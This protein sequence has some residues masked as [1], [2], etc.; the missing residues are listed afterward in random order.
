MSPQEPKDSATP[1]RPSSRWA[2]SSRANRPPRSSGRGVTVERNSPPLPPTGDSRARGVGLDP[3]GAAS[4]PAAGQHCT[5]HTETD[6][7]PPYK[8][9]P[10]QREQRGGRRPQSLVTNQSSGEPQGWKAGLFPDPCSDPA[11]NS[12]GLTGHQHNRALFACR[13]RLL[14]TQTAGHDKL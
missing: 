7:S 8:P 4:L 6:G 3:P 1:G 14:M 2:L 5:I 11:G 9:R 12:Q 13:P 10:L